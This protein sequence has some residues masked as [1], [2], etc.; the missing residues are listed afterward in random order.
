[1]VTVIAVVQLFFLL[2]M[3]LNLIPVPPLD[4]SA[5]IGLLLSDD[6]ARRVQT[7]VARSGAGMFGLLI[8]FMAIRS[9]Y[10]PI[11]GMALN[12]VFVGLW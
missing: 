3:V 5:A 8:A 1:M 4:G 12:V 11:Y 10:W 2:L 9:L 7:A 6:T